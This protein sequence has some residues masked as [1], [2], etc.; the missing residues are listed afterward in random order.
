MQCADLWCCVIYIF[1]FMLFFII[2]RK[3][4]L[5]LHTL[6]K[7]LTLSVSVTSKEM[8][9]VLP[10]YENHTE[11]TKPIFMCCEKKSVPSDSKL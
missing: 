11:R 7:V 3:G 1:T 4:G 2:F 6:I 8:F 10:V 5:A 9:L